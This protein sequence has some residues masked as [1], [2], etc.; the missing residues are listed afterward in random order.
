MVEL[1]D[2]VRSLGRKRIVV[3]GE[4]MLDRY[5][6]GEV[7]RVSPEAPIPVMKLTET[8]ERL[9]GAGCV[10]NNIRTFGSE[11]VPISVIG[12]DTA[13]KKVLDILKKESV[14]TDYILVLEDRPTTVKS[15]MVGYV[16][17]A[18]RATQHIMRMDEEST[19]PIHREIEEKLCGFVT[20]V[21]GECN[22][23]LVS[24]YNKGLLTDRILSFL[25]D[26]GRRYGKMV[27]IDPR[28]CEDYSIYEGATAVTP[29]RYEASLATGEDCSTFGGLSRAAKKMLKEL[30]LNFCLITIDKEGQFLM[31]S[32]GSCEHFPTRARAVYDVSGAG[33]MVLSSLGVVLAHNYPVEAAVEFANIAA[34]IE[35]TKIGAVS[36]T[37]EEMLEEMLA[38]KPSSSEKLKDIERLLESL[39]RERAEGKVIVFTNGCFDI[40][41][42]GHIRLLE[43]AKEQGDVLVV[44]LNSDKSVR[45]IKGK[46]RPINS[47]EDRAKVLASMEAVDYI[48]LFDEET[49]A[50]II[51][52]IRPDVLVKGEDWREKGVV[53]REFVES[54]GGRC[55]LAPMLKGYSTTR[56][57]E[58]VKAFWR[59]SDG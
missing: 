45:T 49:P 58:K 52:R 19:T 43:F 51:E 3:V 20:D 30:S 55:V 44:G 23:M 48:V 59:S 9:G 36:V 42:P 37:K 41:H 11:A 2:I 47:E 57:M 33:D 46:N 34:G 31:R 24:D 29:N 26:S 35:V 50:A 38:H 4:I 28:R 15:R 8:E 10:I 39:R 6:W 5:L 53:G 17:T 21:V 7:E 12:A 40:I 54:Y 22:I 27:I 1:V 18:H 56:I 13:G 16:Q 25:I 32:D 14:P